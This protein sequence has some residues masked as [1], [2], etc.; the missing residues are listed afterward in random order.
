MDERIE[1]RA[2]SA[3]RAEMERAAAQEGQTLSAWLRMVALR[4]AATKNK[5]E[6]LE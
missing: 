2:T 3:Q 1:F 5:K 4:A 6:T